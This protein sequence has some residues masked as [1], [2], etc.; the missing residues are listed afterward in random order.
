MT[1]HENHDVK[2]KLI[3]YVQD[4]VA[5]EQNVK[6]MLDSMINTTSD[7]EMAQ[8]LQEHRDETQRHSAGLSR[9]LEAL[10]GEATSKLKEAPAVVGAL[11]KAV[12]DQARGDKPG[13]NARDGFMTEHLEI[14]AYELL[15]RVATRAGDAATANVARENLADE[16]RMADFIAARWDKIV[17]LTLEEEGTRI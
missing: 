6:Q 15:E 13:R 1:H 7:P 3:Q 17:D 14:A 16:R 4:A 9:R 2:E 8:R 11:G 10:G 12:L 5:M